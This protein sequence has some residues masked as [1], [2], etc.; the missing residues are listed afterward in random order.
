MKTVRVEIG[1]VVLHGFDRIDGRQVAGVAARE[2]TRLIEADAGWPA[3]RGETPA[4]HAQAAVISRAGRSETV[5][6]RVAEIV[7]RELSR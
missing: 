2:L 6:T 5:G 1:E 7:H 4:L 3:L